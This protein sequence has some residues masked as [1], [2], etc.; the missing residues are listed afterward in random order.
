MTLA[1][2]VVVHR[3]GGASLPSLRLNA[4][5]AA[6]QPPGLSVFLGGTPAE[7]SAQ[8]RAVYNTRKWRALAGTVGSATAAAVRAAGFDVIA[9]PTTAFPNHARI[10]HPDAAAGFTDNH[11]AALSA[12]FLTS[13][14]L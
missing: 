1:D 5:D 8:M 2:D 13:T 11:L 7:A 10:V 4:R 9:D 3:V 12:V 14:G 6:V